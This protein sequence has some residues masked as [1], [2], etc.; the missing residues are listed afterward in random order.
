MK[1]KFKI[2]ILIFVLLLQFCCTK[3]ENSVPSDG[4]PYYKFTQDERNK[5]ISQLNVNNEIIYKNQD[6]TLLKFK[7]YSS[8]IEKKSE[9][10]NG[11]LGYSTTY[12]HYDEQKVMMFIEGTSLNSEINILKYPVGSN[13]GTQFPIV[14]TTKFYG[15]FTFPLWN[16]YYENDTYNKFISIDFNIP[17]TTM[18]FNGKTYNK[19]LVLN[20]D[21]TVI[22]EPTNVYPLNVNMIYYDYN[23]GIIG[24]DDLNGKIWRI[25]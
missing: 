18:T 20:S 24:F 3:E 13:Y 2:I 16:G 4:K 9:T 19:V 17:T 6:N 23:F 8:K 10:S 15:Y 7:I 21:K 25:Q 12:F 11:F 14:G 1:N 22:L 5:L